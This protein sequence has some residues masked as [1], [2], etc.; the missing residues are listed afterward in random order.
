MI[1]KRNTVV[2]CGSRFRMDCI[3]YASVRDYIV[4]CRE[5]RLD[6]VN[7]P[8]RILLLFTTWLATGLFQVAAA[9]SLPPLNIAGV[10]EENI[11]GIRFISPVTQESFD[12]VLQRVR[13]RMDLRPLSA[14]ESNRL[15]AEVSDSTYFYAYGFQLDKGWVEEPSFLVSSRLGSPWF[16]YEI[17][18]SSDGELLLLGMTT[19]TDFDKFEFYSKTYGP[20]PKLMT[21]PDGD[22][23]ILVVL[24]VSMLGKI[25]YQELPNGQGTVSTVDAAVFPMTE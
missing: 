19:K 2:P 14:A 7:Y 24:P 16:Q 4:R 8:S 20:T 21:R 23:N 9:Q 17:H 10:S 15:L 11:N 18:K 25:S 3:E 5:A 13:E 6:S 1:R 12:A 22:F